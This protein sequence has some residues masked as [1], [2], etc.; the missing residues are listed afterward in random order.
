MRTARAAQMLRRNRRHLH[1]TRSRDVR[2]CSGAGPG[3]RER[4]G[5]GGVA[6]PADL[7]RRLL[8]DRGA[9]AAGQYV[10]A[11]WPPVSAVVPA[12]DEAAMLPVTLPALLDQDY[13]GD[14]EVILVN[15]GSADGTAEVAERLGRG[16][17]RGGARRDLRV[18]AGSPPPAAWAG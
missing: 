12:R 15:D 13:P 11:A 14:F 6:V 4:S 2:G 1:G 3:G 18:F 9:A 8:A 16:A 7:P 17:R 10:P 5:R